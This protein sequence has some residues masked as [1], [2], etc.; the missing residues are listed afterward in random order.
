MKP[1]VRV[2]FDLAAGPLALLRKHLRVVSRRDVEGLICLL[3]DR[4]DASVM[5]PRLRV[6]SQMAVGTENIDLEA[7]RERGIV[8]TNTPDV[9]TET[10]ADLAFGLILACARGIAK[11]DRFLRG[12]PRPAWRWEPFGYLGRDVHGATLGIVGNGRIGRA[13]ARRAKGFGMKVLFCRP[14]PLARI[15]RESD[16]V[17][18]HVPGRAANRHLIA[19]RELGMMKRT[20]MLINTARGTVVD[21]PALVTALR[22]GTLAGAGLDVYEREPELATGLRGLDNVVI[23]PH[24]GSATVATRHAMATL[25]VRNAVAVLEGRRPITPV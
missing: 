3:R 2:T 25:A 21:E 14:L 18:L 1:S 7:A 24:I 19:A 23:L 13:V 5:T 4:I 10:T 6:I 15:L 16:F 22:R 17:S 8:V 9:L 20:A 11:W 12:G